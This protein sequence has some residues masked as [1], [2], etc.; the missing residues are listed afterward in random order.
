[1]VIRALILVITLLA[2]LGSRGAQLENYPFSIETEKEGDGH[3]IVARNNGPAPVSV[4]VSISDSRNI[5]PDRPFPVFAVVP[6]GGGTLYLARIRPAITGIGYSF[7]TQASWVLGDFNARQ[8]PDAVYRLPYSN[9]MAFRIGQAPGGPITTHTTPESRYAIDIGMPQGA[10]VVAAR[11]GV[12]IYTEANQIYGNKDPDMLSK[13]N[14]IRIRHIDGTIAI[15]AHLAH[16]GVFVYLGQKVTAGTQIGLAGS[17]GYSSG[18][19]LH[20]AVQ[21]VVR[22]ENELIVVSLPFRFFIGNPPVVFSPQYGMLAKADYHSPGQTLEFPVRT[23][24]TQP[25]KTPTSLSPMRTGGSVNNIYIEIP[26]QL[27]SF[28][29]QIPYWLWVVSIFAIVLLAMLLDKKRSSHQ[30]QKYSVRSEPT[31]GSWPEKSPASPASTTPERIG[32]PQ[33]KM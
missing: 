3:R 11:D 17:T 4:K 31:I 12:V 19:H 26:A 18:P 7:R 30:Q 14:E 21:T 32:S 5:E 27:R 13:A 16:G 20:F 8:S 9:G 28:V 24:V 2:S 6:P 15:Y 29:V 23:Q 33:E 25:S 22:A 10:P 1:M